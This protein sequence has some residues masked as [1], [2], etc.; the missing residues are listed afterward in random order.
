MIPIKLLSYDDII[1]KNNKNKNHSSGRSIMDR[2]N[3]GKIAIALSPLIFVLPF[4]L[5]EDAKY[6]GEDYYEN[7]INA[8]VLEANQNKRE[9]NYNKQHWY[10]RT[11]SKSFQLSPLEKSELE[12]ERLEG[13]L[14]ATAA[15]GETNVA[16]PELPAK[17]QSEQVQKDFLQS[18]TESESATPINGTVQ[19]FI[20]S[21]VSAPSPTLTHRFPRGDVVTTSG[22]LS[23]GTVISSPRP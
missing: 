15:G 22:I 3:L 7:D 9:L 14:G 10:K 13:A 19:N 18:L 6:V 8:A 12:V 23:T 2:L 20:K 4:A 5:A 11:T 21:D 16:N 1:T 17:E